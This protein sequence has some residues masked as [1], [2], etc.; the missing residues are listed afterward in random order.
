MIVVSG[1]PPEVY[2][3]MQPV[4]VNAWVGPLTNMQVPVAPVIAAFVGVV[5]AAQFVG[6]GVPQHEHADAFAVNIGFPPAPNTSFP[7]RNKGLYAISSLP[8]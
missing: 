5:Q 1:S 3:H 7:A 6:Q 4:R 8:R 2:A